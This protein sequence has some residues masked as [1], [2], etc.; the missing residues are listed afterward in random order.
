MSAINI[1]FHELIGL[2]IVVVKSSVDTLNGLSGEVVDETQYT[3][4]VKTN[5]GLKIIPK[6]VVTVRI[7]LV[8]GTFATVDGRKILYRPEDRI[9]RLRRKH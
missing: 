2:R 5:N 4:K 7:E 9:T 3:L 6:S 8:D 1:M